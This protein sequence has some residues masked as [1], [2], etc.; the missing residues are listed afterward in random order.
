MRI[1]VAVDTSKIGLCHGLVVSKGEHQRDVDVDALGGQRLNSRN[2]LGCG[3]HLDHHVRSPHDLPEMPRFGDGC[4]GIVGRTWR[5]LEA[6]EAVRAVTVVVHRSKDISRR[7]DVLD[8]ETF[9]ERSV[10]DV[11]VGI[12]RAMQRGIVIGTSGDG[13][14]ENGR[15][16]GHTAQTILVDINRCS[17]P[18][19]IRLR[20]IWSNQ[21]N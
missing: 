4:S 20:L 15:V 19:V 14:V 21:T 5:D 17:P 18:P 13:L 1:R 7:L 9:G 8:D 6:H 12:E 3:W 16:A 2:A 11:A 10:A